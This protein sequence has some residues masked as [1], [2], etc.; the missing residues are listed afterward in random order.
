MVL[1]LI[2]AGLL[3]LGTAWRYLVLGSVAMARYRSV[4]FGLALLVQAP[5]RLLTFHG[6][7]LWIGAMIALIVWPFSA[8]H[9][10][11]G[12]A[13][14]T[15]CGLWILHALVQL[16]DGGHNMTNMRMVDGRLV[17][18][19]APRQEGLVLPYLPLIS[20]WFR[21]V[22]DSRVDNLRSG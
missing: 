20:S 10:I 3:Y 12:V 2:L 5:I 13:A 1:I 19:K 8:G 7:W 15:Y 14:L 21:R 11:I 6:W 22:T 16:W 9:W 4:S 17:S 18:A